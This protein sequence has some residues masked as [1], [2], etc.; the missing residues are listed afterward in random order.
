[1]R[2]KTR[3]VNCKGG[4]TKLECTNC[5]NRDRTRMDTGLR[6]SYAE[7]RVCGWCFDVETGLGRMRHAQD[8]SY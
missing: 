8:K 1:M 3:S 7:C 4:R 6:S 2:K 5:G